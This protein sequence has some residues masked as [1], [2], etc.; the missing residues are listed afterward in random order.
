MKRLSVRFEGRVQQVGFRFFAE[1]VSTNFNITGWIKNLDDGDV[2]LEIQGDEKELFNFVL[3]YYGQNEFS[4]KELE[5]DFGNSA[6]ATIRTF[7]LKMTEK[8][9]FEE[10]IYRNRKKY[11]LKA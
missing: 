8:G 4:T 1:S 3:S 10:H 9:L 11:N 7:V 6:Y 2:L 5:R